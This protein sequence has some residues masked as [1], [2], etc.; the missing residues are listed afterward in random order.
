MRYCYAC[1]ECE[2]Y[3]ISNECS[4]CHEANTE[5]RDFYSSFDAED[6]WRELDD[7]WLYLMCANA[8]H[9]ALLKKLL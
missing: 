1:G 7:P 8:K 9:A 6:Y 3:L 4:L 2:E 5:I